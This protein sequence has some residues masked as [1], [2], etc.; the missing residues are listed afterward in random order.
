MQRDPNCLFCKI[1]AGE[2]PAQRLLETDDAIV[3]ADINP[4][5]PL[6]ALAI[7]RRHIASIAIVTA[8]DAATL[9]AVFTAATTVAHQHGVDASGYRL[10]LNHGDDAGQSV[11]HLHVH[12]LG[13]KPM[14]WPPFPP[15]A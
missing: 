9:A 14:G 13:G 3:I 10:V 2:I 1:I 8:A 12:V 11:P 6:H 7:P 15:T 4:Q 5:A